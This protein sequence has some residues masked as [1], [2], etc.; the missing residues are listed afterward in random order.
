M[1]LIDALDQVLKKEEEGKLRLR[2][3]VRKA[4]DAR[5]EGEEKATKLYRKLREGLK[6]KTR[7]YRAGWEKRLDSLGERL[8][9]ERKGEVERLKREAAKKGKKAGQEAY[10]FLVGQA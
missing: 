7:E 10:D 8:K 9:K 4:D 1:K 2:E 5:Y 3:A 6:D